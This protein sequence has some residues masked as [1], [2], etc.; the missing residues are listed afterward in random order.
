ML[1]FARFGGPGGTGSGPRGGSKALRT[2]DK[3]GRCVMAAQ[4]WGVSKLPPLSSRTVHWLDNKSLFSGA[5]ISIPAPGPL[6]KTDVLSSG[7]IFSS[8]L[9]L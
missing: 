1:L 7:I 6:I 8:W 2:T 3:G 5:K 4:V 9:Y